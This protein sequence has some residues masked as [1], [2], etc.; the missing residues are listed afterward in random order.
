MVSFSELE[1]AALGGDVELLFA[2]SVAQL[3]CDA[4][5]LSVLESRN[6]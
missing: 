6:R 4:Q 1:M 5:E 3:K 2:R